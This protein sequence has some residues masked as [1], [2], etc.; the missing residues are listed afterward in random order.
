MAFRTYHLSQGGFATSDAQV[1]EEYVAAWD[2]TDADAAEI[3]RGADLS[4]VD[5]VLVITP[6]PPDPVEEGIE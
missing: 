3:A 1:P 2:V 5:G 6:L 4:V